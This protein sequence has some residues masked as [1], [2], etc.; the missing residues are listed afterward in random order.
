VTLIVV[1]IA[2]FAAM[3]GFRYDDGVNKTDLAKA[4]AKTLETA[5]ICYRLKFGKN[6]A[7]L[8]DLGN[9]PDGS[10]YVDPGAL[11]DP[12]GQPYQYDPAGPRNQGEKPD[13]WTTGSDGKLIGNWR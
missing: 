1:L 8:D 6:P 3:F 11:N 12:W 5:V 13:I 9:P 7:K 4:G 10:P 2:I